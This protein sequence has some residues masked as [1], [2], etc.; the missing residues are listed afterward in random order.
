MPLQTQRFYLV[1]LG[2]IFEFE[3]AGMLRGLGMFQGIFF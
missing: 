3:T 1:Q 2:K